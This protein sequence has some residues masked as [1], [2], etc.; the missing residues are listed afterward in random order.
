MRYDA[1][2]YN[3]GMVVYDSKGMG[4]VYMYDA[5]DSNRGMLV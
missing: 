1:V 2:D 5:V 3:R 4:G